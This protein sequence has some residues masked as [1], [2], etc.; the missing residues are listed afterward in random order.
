MGK[1][2]VECVKTMD[3]IANAVESSI[4]YW[5]RFSTRECKFCNCNYEFKINHSIC[6]TAMNME[7]NAIFSYTSEGDTPRMVSSFSPSCP[8]Y[9]ITQNEIT[10]RQLALSWGVYPMLVKGEE[11]INKILVNG[12]KQVKEKGELKDGDTVVIAGGGTVVPDSDET[13]NRTIG[14][15]I[16]I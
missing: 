14:G 1:F 8:I 2:P 12:M 6:T 7:A 9:A 3:K 16:R 5:K 4:K 13:I 10:Y 15:V 11:N